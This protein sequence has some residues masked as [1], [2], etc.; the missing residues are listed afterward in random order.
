MR[1]ALTVIPITAQALFSMF[2]FII[3]HHVTGFH[4]HGALMGYICINLTTPCLMEHK[5]SG[6]GS[7]FSGC[8]VCNGQGTFLTLSDNGKALVDHV[9]KLYI[10]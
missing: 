10:E 6:V 4:F 8:A 2:H 3:H 7:L 1:L 5:K 9:T